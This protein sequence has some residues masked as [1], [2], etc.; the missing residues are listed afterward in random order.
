MIQLD[1]FLRLLHSLQSPFVISR[2]QRPFKAICLSSTVTCAPLDLQGLKPIAYPYIT[3]VC[4]VLVDCIMYHNAP[5]ISKVK[6]I[7]LAH[8]PLPGLLILQLTAY[9][10][11][12]MPCLMITQSSLPRL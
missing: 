1:H 2:P 4:L 5:G 6:D 12:T 11:Q 8:S 9:A 7:H 3:P 10:M